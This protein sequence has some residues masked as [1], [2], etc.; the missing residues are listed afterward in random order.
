M[1]P[2]M[3]EVTCITTYYQLYKV[4]SQVSLVTALIEQDHFFY[5]SSFMEYFSGNVFKFLIFFNILTFN[6]SFESRWLSREKWITLA[7]C[8]DC[9]FATD[10]IH[11][12]ARAPLTQDQAHGTKPD[13]SGLVLSTQNLSHN[14]DFVHLQT[15][16]RPL[17][18][19]GC[20]WKRC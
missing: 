9:L 14:S 2:Y 7:L 10:V 1:W 8:C 3:F 12:C 13:W 11:S 5:L 6:K 15:W 20:C 4:T 18:K 19:L 17:G 16:Y